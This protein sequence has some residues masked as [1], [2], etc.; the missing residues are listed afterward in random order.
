MDLLFGA[1]GG[2]VG[3]IVFLFL[4]VLAILWFILPFAVLG[5]NKRLDKITSHLVTINNNICEIV[6]YVRSQKEANDPVMEEEEGAFDK[7]DDWSIDPS[8]IEQ[9]ECGKK[10]VLSICDG[11]EALIPPEQT[12]SDY[13]ICRKYKLSALEGIVSLRQEQ[14]QCPRCNQMNPNSTFKCLHRGCNYSQTDA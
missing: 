10:I 3:L 4:V 11:C 9:G 12:K 14:W 13:F 7:W 6:E 2:V 1:L 5:T 8:L